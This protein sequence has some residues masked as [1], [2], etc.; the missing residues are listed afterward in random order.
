MPHVHHVF[1]T[2]RAFH[3]V[4]MF[5][6]RCV[7]HLLYSFPYAALIIVHVEGSRAMRSSVYRHPV[8]FWRLGVVNAKRQRGV[9]ELRS[10]RRQVLC[11][12]RVPKPQSLPGHATCDGHGARPL[13][14]AAPGALCGLILEPMARPK[15]GRAIVGGGGSLACFGVRKEFSRR[16]KC[17][18]G[19]CPLLIAC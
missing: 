6:T 7:Y 10:A 3:A 9:S 2:F 4:F 12:A 19:L 18:A 8:S 5:I 13:K 15:S 16:V 14:G 1:M 11:S 17:L